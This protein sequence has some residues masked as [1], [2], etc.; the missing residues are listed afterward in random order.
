MSW[1][2]PPTRENAR[3]IVAVMIVGI[4]IIGYNFQQRRTVSDIIHTR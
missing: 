2:W 3:N 1:I 4:G